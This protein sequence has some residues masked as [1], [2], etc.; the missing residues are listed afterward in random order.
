MI[1][2]IELLI[3]LLFN[4]SFTTNSFV[5][6]LK[7]AKV[8]PIYK[9]ESKLDCAKILDKLMHN[10]LYKFLNDNK[11]IYPL[12][13]NFRQKYSTSLIL[14]HITQT[15]KEAFD[16]RR[17]GCG[18]FVDLQNVFDSVNHNILMGKFRHYG[19]IGVAYSLF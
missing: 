1:F 18:I 9:K 16:Q 2:L 4:L 3:Y 17:Y 8:I 19:N 12:N 15:I 10:R 11:I 14:I 6:L 13:F 5:I 7:T